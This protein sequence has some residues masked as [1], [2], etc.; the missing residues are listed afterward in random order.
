MM[1][2]TRT[3]G[4]LEGG[5]GVSKGFKVVGESGVV[6]VGKGNRVGVVGK[7]VDVMENGV[8]GFPRICSISLESVSRYDEVIYN[9]SNKIDNKIPTATRRCSKD[10]EIYYNL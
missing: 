9:S 6:V 2:L 8:V 3:D 1:S 5:K 4:L 10:V 7:W